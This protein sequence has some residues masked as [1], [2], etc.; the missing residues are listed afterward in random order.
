MRLFERSGSKLRKAVAFLVL[1]AAVVSQVVAADVY[2]V[3]YKMDADVVVYVTNNRQEADLYVAT[4]TIGSYAR[5]HDHYW[6]FVPYQ[7]PSVIK[8]YF[9]TQRKEADVVVYYARSFL[10]WKRPNKFQHR[11]H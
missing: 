4:T 6:R 9:T 7:L 1:V 8:V 5:Q 2:V 11:L 3:R 10:G